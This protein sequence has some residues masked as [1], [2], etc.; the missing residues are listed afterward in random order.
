MGC[1][2]DCGSLGRANRD[3]GGVMRS[4]R[5]WA[6]VLVV[7]S[8]VGTMSS[9][10]GAATPVKLVDPARARTIRSFTTGFERASDFAGF[11]VT[12]NTASTHLALSNEVV[13]SGGLAGKGWITGPT[14]TA[15]PDGPNHRGYPTI[16]L[17]KLPG[18]GFRR[19]VII[20]L[21]VWVDAALRPGEW[22]SLAT[23]S[24]DASDHWARV[25][26]VNVGPDGHLS[27]FHVPRQGEGKPVQ[28]NTTTL[29]PLRQWV[30]IR[31]EVDFSRRGAIAV[32]QD[33]RLVT[34]AGIEGGHGRLEQ[35]HFGIYASP[36]VTNA[37][38]YN[39]DLSIRQVRGPRVAPR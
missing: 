10:A 22:L 4:A 28:A 23:L 6:I 8:T 14:S 5:A 31:M 15:D 30:H 20:D 17:W 35:A 37:T 11:Y 34:T 12:P 26:T 24:A 27:L 16:Q 3:P 32:W 19:S 2:A 7:L 36:S 21:S 18:G 39:D 25:V 29:F 13:E 38:V 1:A 9:T 33:G